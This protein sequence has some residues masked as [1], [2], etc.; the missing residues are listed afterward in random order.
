MKVIAFLRRIAIA[1]SPRSLGSCLL[2]V[3]M[4]VC[5]GGCSSSTSDPKISNPNAGSA[6]STQPAAASSSGLP[7]PCSLVTQAEVE[8]ALGKGATMS[9]VFNER[10]GM[11]ECR[12][13][14]A[15][16]GKIEVVLIV[17]HPAVSWDAVKKV[18]LP[19]SSDGKS[20]SGMGDDGFVG[21]AVGYNV[22]KG[23]RYVQVFGAVTND[24][25]ANDK[26]T[27]YLAEKASSR[28]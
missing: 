2:S 11:Q 4:V 8:T 12:L 13:K 19:P 15:A 16:P 17:V 20:L 27:R 23:S 9:P 22:R 1:L 3:A 28:L 18:M 14:P 26:A 21:R 5:L 25:A 6:S 24:D 7:E 10:I